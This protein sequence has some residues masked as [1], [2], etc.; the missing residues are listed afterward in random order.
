MWYLNKPGFFDI[1]HLVLGN[2]VI[3]GLLDSGREG[4]VLLQY[5]GYPVQTQNLVHTTQKL[6]ER[7]YY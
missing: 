7:Y 3:I 1:Y 2:G 6:S 4:D 5:T